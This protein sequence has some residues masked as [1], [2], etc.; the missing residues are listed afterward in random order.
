MSIQLA[1][2]RPTRTR[3]ENGE[4]PLS[5]HVH[6]TQ[7]STFGSS[8]CTGA[9]STLLCRTQSQQQAF[10]RVEAPASK[11]AHRPAG[12]RNR[13]HAPPG[14]RGSRKRADGRSAGPR[15]GVTTALGRHA[16]GRLSPFR[17]MGRRMGSRGPPQ[18]IARSHSRTHAR[19]PDGV[20][21]IRHGMVVIP[22]C[23]AVEAADCERC[24]PSSASLAHGCNQM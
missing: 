6:A 5:A 22:R 17:S 2:P 18:P 21:G 9:A 10:R 8:P 20:G 3:P 14:T 1:P 19:P 7:N 11:G 13:P 16:A 24:C 23:P 12:S 4:R 15:R